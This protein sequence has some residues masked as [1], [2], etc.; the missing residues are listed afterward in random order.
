M[1]GTARGTMHGSCLPWI[2]STSFCFSER[3]TESCGFP[4]DGVGL[5]AARKT[6]GMPLEMPPRM[7]P[8][9]FGSVTTLP[10]SMR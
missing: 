1:H 10:V 7:A 2:W 9:G 4:M 3:R 6:I 8:Q 5:T